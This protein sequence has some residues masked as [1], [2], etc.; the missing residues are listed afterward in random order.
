M[1]IL[2]ILQVLRL[3]LL[4][5]LGGG[6]FLDF[7]LVGLDVSSM[8]NSWFFSC[9]IL[10]FWL[11]VWVLFQP[12]W[13]SPF[14]MNNAFQAQS[15]GFGCDMLCGLGTSHRPR[16]QTVQGPLLSPPSKSEAEGSRIPMD[17]S[18]LCHEKKVMYKRT[19]YDVYMILHYVMFDINMLEL[20]THTHTHSMS[21]VISDEFPK[22][23]ATVSADL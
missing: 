12:H 10:V 2:Y 16:S 9:L 20:E 4:Q 17:S 5:A 13:E 15:M 1:R 19:F 18:S 23:E 14:L 11:R 22:T 6:Q 7:E 3:V 8:Q 21:S